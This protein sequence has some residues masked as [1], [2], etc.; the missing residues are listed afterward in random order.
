MLARIKLSP[1]SE[2]A[3]KWAESFT[4]LMASKRELFFHYVIVSRDHKRKT[5]FSFVCLYSRASLFFFDVLY[6][7]M[8]QCRIIDASSAAATS[9]NHGPRALVGFF[10]V[11]KEFSFGWKT[12]QII[13]LRIHVILLQRDRRSTTNF[14]SWN[15]ATKIW[16]FGRPSRT[17]RTA[18]PK[19]W[20]LKPSRFTRIF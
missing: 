17:T 16:N 20:P 15:S 19:I 1:G 2:E 12:A 13:N 5:I 3:Q 4:A 9:M 11:T 6:K 10:T 14:Y 18:N 7:L 8:A